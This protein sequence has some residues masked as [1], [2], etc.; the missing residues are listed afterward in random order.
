MDISFYGNKIPEKG[1]FVSFQFTKITGDKLELKLNNFDFEGYMVPKN[2]TLK[3]KVKSWNNIAPLKKNMIGIVEDNSNSNLELSMAY[4]DKDSKSYKN[5]EKLLIDN[6]HIYSFF[7][8][9]C[10]KIKSSFDDFW[11]NNIYKL[12]TL[13]TSFLDYCIK[14]E[15]EINKIIQNNFN[16]H[17]ELFQELFKNLKE[18]IN[19]DSMIKKKKVGIISNLGIESTKNI[20]KEI[21]DKYEN[22]IIKLDSIPYYYIHYK[23]DTNI[24]DVIQDLNK[25]NDNQNIFIKY[26]S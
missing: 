8:K 24:D 20:F 17:F 3:K 6:Y 25:Y 19:F 18:K 14:N 9:F 23:N 10:F 22:I 26:T 21:T 13:N 1:Q 16:E 12:I 5:F 11:K 15:N 7:K 4:V 2:A